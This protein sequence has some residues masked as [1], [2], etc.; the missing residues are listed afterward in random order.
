MGKFV[1][2][3]SV[4]QPAGGGLSITETM[5]LNE[6]SRDSL[7]IKFCSGEG[8]EIGAGYRPTAVA[9]GTKVHYAD[10]RSDEEAA[11]Y[12]NRPDV[13]PANTLEE[14]SG[15]TFDFLMAHHV[16]EHTSNVI[17]VMINWITSLKDG[18]VLFLSVPERHSC[19]DA[20]RLLTP[21]TH[22]LL[23]YVYK[24]SDNDYESREHICS[25]LWGWI[26]AGGLRNV[27]K[28][29][30]AKLV[31]D[32]LNSPTNDLHWHTFNFYSLRFVTDVAASILGRRLEVL[33]AFD[34][35]KRGQ[36]HR[37]VARVYR[38]KNSV[39]PNEIKR[40]LN[41]RDTLRDDINSLAL[42]RLEGAS[43][44]SLFEP[45]NKKIYTVREGKLCWVLHPATLEELGIAGNDNTP[46]DTASLATK[47]IG[48]AIG[49]STSS[50]ETTVPPLD[51][52]EP[53]TKRLKGLE[54]LPGLEMSPGAAPVI[55]KDEFSVSYVD[56]FDHKDSIGYFGRSAVQI[57][58]LL[59]DKF[60]DEVLPNAGFH[61]LVSSHVI[62]HIPD[63]IQF[64]KS[65]ANVLKPNGKIV[66]YVPDKRYTFDVLRPISSIEDI[67]RAHAASLRSPS[68]EMARAAYSYSDFNAQM[69]ELWAGKYH[70][71]PTHGKDE[72][73]RILAT[74]DLSKADLHCFTFTP[75]SF[76][77]LI[78]HTQESYLPN[79]KVIE[80]V[81][82]AH[83][84]NEFLVELVIS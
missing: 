57:D 51:R 15:K 69:A 23:D 81:D 24:I 53:V 54:R 79:L 70:P 68:M 78:S 3:P 82:T 16:L 22:F 74:V 76:K 56:K 84:A 48:R 8:I 38:Q 58:L 14:F 1:S 33:H 61:Y 32:A 6:S 11:N 12:F 5:L 65:A 30:A 59:G 83:G 19:G 37:L 18:G 67:E 55:L 35:F 72:I 73:E 43:L 64:F 13:V 44:H 41:Y 40:L 52:R 21:P 63:F 46:F 45:D 47:F 66:M 9:P 4:I 27:D 77:R 49:S 71:T 42:N 31:T 28:F 34:A 2:D 36:E 20:A 39:I 29:T 10:K 26:D 50:V 25:F 62:E 75:Q 80:I 60:I 7:S 17:E